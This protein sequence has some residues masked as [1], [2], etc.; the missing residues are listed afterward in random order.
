MSPQTLERIAEI[1]FDARM[2]LAVAAGEPSPYYRQI[3][4]SPLEIESYHFAGLPDGKK[5]VWRDRAR[6]AIERLP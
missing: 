5:D 6:W 3:P 4:G 2:E 1:L